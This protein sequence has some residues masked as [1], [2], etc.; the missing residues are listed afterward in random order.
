M[1]SKLDELKKSVKKKFL[2]EYEKNNTGWFNWTYHDDRIIEIAMEKLNDL[3]T[4]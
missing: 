3:K 2:S 1:T 4:R